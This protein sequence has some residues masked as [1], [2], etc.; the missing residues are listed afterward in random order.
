LDGH[1]LE[2]YL[3]DILCPTT[4]DFAWHPSSLVN[5]ER[6]CHNVDTT[7][8]RQA[9]ILRIKTLSN[10]TFRKFEKI[11]EDC[12]IKSFIEKCQAVQIST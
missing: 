10:E 9:E 7:R 11:S 6:L 3:L 8:A 4:P 2:I 5:T 12:C 1:L